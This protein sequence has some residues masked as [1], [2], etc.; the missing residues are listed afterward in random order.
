MTSG[1]VLCVSVGQPREVM[2]D[3]CVVRTSIFKSPV[4]LVRV[5]DGTVLD[6][7]DVELRVAS[8]LGPAS[9]EIVSQM[10]QQLT[11]SG[12]AV[13]A[14]R[15]VWIR[16]GVGNIAAQRAG[17]ERHELVCARIGGTSVG[18]CPRE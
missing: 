2:A 9:G 4:D 15:T 13:P 5:S 17:S 3:D 12:G 1:R 8:A 11:L 18:T 10:E 16:P 7:G 14:A 6:H